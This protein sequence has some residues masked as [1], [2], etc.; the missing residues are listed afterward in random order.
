M[1]GTMFSEGRTVM[2]ASW[3]AHWRWRPS[4]TP[5]SFVQAIER[6]RNELCSRVAVTTKGTTVNLR[7]EGNT[8]GFLSP[9][10]VLYG[11]P[12]GA[13]MLHGFGWIRD[14]TLERSS[15]PIR[16]PYARR[17]VQGASKCVF[18]IHRQK[19][20]KNS[21]LSAHCQDFLQWR[22]ILLSPLCR[23]IQ[24][25]TSGKM[26]ERQSRGLL[27]SDRCG[28]CCVWATCVWATQQPKPNQKTPRP[29]LQ[30]LGVHDAELRCDVLQLGSQPR[31]LAPARHRDHFRAHKTD[32][33]HG[34]H[35][36][37]GWSSGCSRTHRNAWISAS[38]ATLV[39]SWGAA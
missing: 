20:P 13:K 9:P 18:C 29:R 33:R 6:G 19:A 32:T 12:H 8:H 15:D 2:S 31:A 34:W 39:R 4:P 28:A 38:L 27:E 3:S 36:S 25:N 22:R 10:R 35:R 17:A 24:K 16:P 21:P 37:A 7:R 11:F 14:S 5:K 23:W 26:L 1:A 30:T